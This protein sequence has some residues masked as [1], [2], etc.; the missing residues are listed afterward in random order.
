MYTFLRLNRIIKTQPIF[1]TILF[2]YQHNYTMDAV[3]D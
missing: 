3:S 2:V 1:V